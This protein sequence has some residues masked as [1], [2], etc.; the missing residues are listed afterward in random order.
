ME[1]VD[2]QTRAGG[3]AALLHLQQRFMQRGGAGAVG[4]L[5]FAQLHQLHA[6]RQRRVQPAQESRQAAREPMELMP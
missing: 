4:P 5:R 2:Q 3:M 1:A 6:T